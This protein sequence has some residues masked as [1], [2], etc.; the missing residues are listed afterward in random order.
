[1]LANQHSM[2]AHNLLCNKIYFNTMSSTRKT[3]E[4][5]SRPIIAVLVNVDWEKP[6]YSH[7]HT[8]NCA[9]MRNLTTPWIYIDDINAQVQSHKFRVT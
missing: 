6:G 8:S 1:M 9:P 2:K 5:F 4:R 3:R 7:Y